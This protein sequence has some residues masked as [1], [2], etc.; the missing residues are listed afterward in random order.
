MNDTLFAHQQKKLENGYVEYANNLGLDTSV[1]GP[2]KQVQ[3]D[4]INEDVEG[5]CKSE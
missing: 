3:I 2:V 4:R 5:G 1:S